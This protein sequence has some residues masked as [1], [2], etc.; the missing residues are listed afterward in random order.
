MTCAPTT[1]TWWRIFCSGIS[2]AGVVLLVLLLISLADGTLPRELFPDRPQTW[3]WKAAALTLS[4]PVPFHVFA[5][6]LMLQHRQLSPAWQK[7]AWG[8]IVAS[9]LWLGAALMAKTVLLA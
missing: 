4:L 6:G 3:T 7:T 8:S 5:I 9:G 2:L 1:R